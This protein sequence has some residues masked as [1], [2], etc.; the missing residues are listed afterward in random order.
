MLGHS[1]GIFPVGSHCCGRGQLLAGCWTQGLSSSLLVAQRPP[2]VLSL[3]DVSNMAAS[4]K[5]VVQEGNR[6]LARCKPLPFVTS[7]QKNIFLLL[8]RSKSL[9]SAYVQGK[10]ITPSVSTEG[11]GG[12]CRG[13]LWCNLHFLN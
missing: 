7:P 9:S 12:H 5:R 4:S 1:C 8:A 11:I 6:L 10:G 2:S 13:P 3:L